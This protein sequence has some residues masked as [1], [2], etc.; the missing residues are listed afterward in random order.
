MHSKL[1]GGATFVMEG[2]RESIS[3]HFTLSLYRLVNMTSKY[4]VPQNIGKFCFMVVYVRLG[5]V[6]N[7]LKVG[8][9]WSIGR[10][11]ISRMTFVN[12]PFTCGTLTCTGFMI[13]Q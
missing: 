4:P 13:Y 10:C 2:E 8:Q 3:M 11:P 9:N 5:L 7:I 12:F 1:P 6:D